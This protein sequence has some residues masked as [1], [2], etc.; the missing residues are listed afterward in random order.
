MLAAGVTLVY[1][2]SPAR[3]FL[4][5]EFLLQNVSHF[6]THL[7]FILSFIPHRLALTAAT[8]AVQPCGLT[9]CGMMKLDR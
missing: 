6:R 5:I 7:H 4:D 8:F 9:C 2:V 1:P 3:K